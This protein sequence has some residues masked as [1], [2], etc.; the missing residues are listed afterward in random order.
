MNIAFRV[1]ASDAIGTGHAMR[2]LTL[3]DRLAVDGHGCRFVMRDNAGVPAGLITGR[4]HSLTLLDSP[5]CPSGGDLAHSA[6]LGVSQERDAAETLAALADVRAGPIDWLV[7]D[8]YGIDFR[9]HRA[10]RPAVRQILV[11]DDIAD[12]RHDCELLLDQN[13]QDAPGRYDALIPKE[14]EVLTG[15]RYALLRPAFAP[16]RAKGLPPREGELRKLLIYLGGVDADGATMLALEALA[17]AGLDDLALDVVAG[18]RNPHRDAITRWCAVRPSATLYGD[19]ADLAGMMLAA[20][21]AIGAAGSTAWERCCLGLPTLLLTI[22]ENQRPGARALAREGAAMWPGDAALLSAD[23]VAGALRTLAMCPDLRGLIGARAAALVDGIGADRVVRAML[24]D[25]MTLRAA[26][27]A[28]CDAV[29]QWRNDERT[30]RHVSDPAPIALDS[31][32]QWFAGVIGGERPV[33]LL[34]GEIGGKP[35]G[36]LRFDHQGAVATI[37][38]YLVP[39]RANRGEGQLLLRAG[40]EWI[41]S[42]RPGTEIVE[43]L[44]LAQNEASHRAFRAAGFQPYAAK[45]RWVMARGESREP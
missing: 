15:P 41:A 39:G 14:C 34:I 28:D 45:Y 42:H 36:V 9:W 38:I 44:V 17:I 29:W 30:R 25:A 37:S 2:C 16:L 19:G 12:R 8:H 4:G 31:H 5:D 40:R 22:A 23:A 3:A 6:W 24:G 20:D 35:A 27:P 43:A 1:D 13:L 32:R 7:S 26:G 33:D 21:L 10:M 11:I 18:N